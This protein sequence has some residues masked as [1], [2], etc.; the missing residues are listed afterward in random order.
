MTIHTNKPCYPV[1]EER[2][3]QF[4]KVFEK[5]GLDRPASY[6]P[7]YEVFNNIRHINKKFNDDTWEYEY[8]YEIF[9][10]DNISGELTS[11]LSKL[12][13]IMERLG[14]RQTVL[15]LCK[16]SIGSVEY[17]INLMVAVIDIL[18]IDNIDS[19]EYDHRKYEPIEY[20]THDLRIPDVIYPND[21]RF[22]K[23]LHNKLLY[24]MYSELFYRHNNIYTNKHSSHMDLLGLLFRKVSNNHPKVIH[25]ESYHRQKLADD[26]ATDYEER[27]RLQ[28][29]SPK[30]IFEEEYHQL[31]RKYDELTDGIR[32]TNELKKLKTEY[33]ANQHN[34]K[35][36]NSISIYYKGQ[37]DM[38]TEHYN[39]TGESMTQTF[40]RIHKQERQAEVATNNK[41]F[42]PI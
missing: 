26:M 1:D 35:S 28:N 25:F 16:Y 13:D 3:E 39:K 34:S 17:L 22:K 6:M 40:D 30:A 37:A 9:K 41:R 4:N 8:S 15:E 38:Y 24:V 12:H 23:G 7:T 33:E 36:N 42:F 5:Y 18:P 2:E 11:T 21:I 19:Y 32:R 14:F 29:I 20:R 10:E 31:K 27:I